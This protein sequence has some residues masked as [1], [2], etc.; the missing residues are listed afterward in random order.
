MAKIKKWSVDP[1]VLRLYATC[2]ALFCGTLLL[3]S[4]AIP[5]DFLD[6]DD[7]DYV[8]DNPPVQAGLTWTG[9]RWAMTANVA[10]NWHPLTLLSHMLDCQLFDG[11]APGHHVTN[12]FWHALNAVMAFLAFRRLTGAFW[13]SALSAALFAWH[14]LRVESVAWIAERKDVL[15]GFFGLFTLW[16]YAVYAE[17]RRE[18]RG[19]AAPWYTITLAAFAAGLSCK[20][21]LVTLPFLL[22]LLDWWPLQRP[23]DGG[24]QGAGARRLLVEKI[25]FFLLSAA[26]GVVTYCFQK[27]AGAVGDTFAL[28]AR[29]ANATV[30]VVRYLGKFFWPFDLAVGYPLPNHWPRADIVGA[31]LLVLAITGTVLWQRRQRPWLFVGWFWFLGMLVPVIGLVQAGLQ[32]MADRYTYLPM[33]GVQ[34]MLLWTWREAFL[35]AAPRWLKLATVALLLGCGAIRTWDQLGVWRNS[36]TLQE[37]AL[38]VTRGNYLAEFYLGTTLLNEKHP[39]EAIVHLRQALEFKPDFTADHY[40]LG[41]ALQKLGWTDEA[42][43]VFK[44]VLKDNPGYG[45]ADYNLGALL[46]ELKRPA[47]AVA[48]LKAAL[49]TKPDYDPAYVALGTAWSDLNHPQE[50]ITNFAKALVFN[51][52]NAVAH[53][54]LANTLVDLRRTQE[55]LLHYEEAIRLDPA[56]ESAHCNYGNALRVLKRPDA[57]GAQ[58]RQALQLQP[59]DAAAHYGLGTVLEDAGKMD[60]ALDSYN[61]AVRL[62]PDYAEAQYEIGA[63]RLDQNRPEE[64]IIHFQTAVKNRSDYDPAYLG[65]GLASAQLGRQPEA[66]GY[67]EQVLAI[68]P[69]NADALCCL[70][71]ALRREGRLADAIPYFERTLGL[72]PADAEAHA[73]LGK[74]LYR[75]GQPAEAIPHLEQA[76]KLH[77]EFPGISEIL[78]AAQS[79]PGT[80]G[81]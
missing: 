48:Y 45:V 35:A 12:V 63:I 26:S 11:N 49:K 8:T 13:A 25:P 18:N 65:L 51:P 1:A 10:A 23:M 50:A 6:L 21:M 59:D 64:A 22:L 55:A 67:Y 5:H 34:L 81:K 36:H 52:H 44:A 42:M 78:A 77:P 74:V 75:M 27:E 30:S 4:R 62:K 20:P 72:K 54:D 31:T 37:H 7:G 9:V 16:A 80:G 40:R 70:G 15:S 28:N 2:L 43:T 14:P 38:A 61:E 29:L 47:E 56:F 39:A 66:I 19:G 41:V 60:E 73:E 24:W 76:L 3:F 33:L 71:V 58:Y 46:L 53:F 68:T 69:D 17:R 32:A 79:G 57:A